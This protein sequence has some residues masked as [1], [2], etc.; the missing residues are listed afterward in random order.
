MTGGS[1][2]EAPTG[3]LVSVVMP[4][5]NAEPFLSAAIESVRAQSWPHWELLIVDDCSDDASHET[6]RR[7]A[8]ADP[9]I[10]VFRLPEN[11]GPAVARNRAIEAA[12]GRWIAFLDADDLWTPDKLE[13]QLAFMRARDA[14]LSYTAYGKIDQHGNIV[15][16]PVPA[17]DFVTYDEFLDSSVISCNSAIYDV[18]KI[19]KHYFKD[20]PLHEDYVYWLDVL[21]HIE[22]AYGINEPL[23]FYR[24]HA[25][26]RS[27]NKLR[28]ARMQ[29]HIYREIERL[30]L[31]RSLRHFAVYAW[32][33]LRKRRG[34]G[35]RAAGAQRPSNSR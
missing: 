29:W 10:R 13:R 15:G 26:S 1:R 35:A 23:A 4:C 19:G 33:G 11:K 28:A 32:R 2:E 5:H 31:V 34:G 7:H 17:P 30:P 9:R 12:R 27:H 25:G 21:K 20:V 16:P 24:L 6:A 18:T 22:R 3:D 8:D 14:A